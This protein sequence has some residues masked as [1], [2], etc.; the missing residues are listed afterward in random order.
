MHRCT[1]RCPPL[2]LPEAPGADQKHARKS[3]GETPMNK[4]LLGAVA[5]TALGAIFTQPAS[6]TTFKVEHSFCAKA[7]CTDGSQPFGTPVA[8]ASGN[9]YGG[10]S[11]GGKF[12]H[13]AIYQ[14]VLQSGAWHVT[15]IHNFCAHANCTDGAQPQ[16]PLIVDTDGNLY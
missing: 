16:G 15:D 9:Y 6:A 13:G 7:D 4:L 11:Q 8:D 5:I 14:A 1:V 12:G 2:Q 10:L 3:L